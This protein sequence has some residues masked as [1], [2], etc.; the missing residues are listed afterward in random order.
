MSAVP[1]SRPL[2]PV[3]SSERIQYIDVL[4][5]FA[6]YGVLLANIIW[7]ACDMVLTPAATRQ[8]PT[9]AADRIVKYLVVFFIDGKFITLFSFLFAVGFTLQMQRALQRGGSAIALYAR[10][11]A[12]LMV[13]GAAHLVL[14]WFG[15]ILLM[16]GFL[17]FYFS[18]YG[19]GDRGS[20]C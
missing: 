10:R 1:A 18:R 12:V 4:R 6:L 9:H 7:M 19:P 17:G 3:S 14:I 20:P 11:V 2:Q 5:G 8:L 15:D 13:I 16:Y